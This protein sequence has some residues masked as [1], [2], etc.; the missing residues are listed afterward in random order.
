MQCGLTGSS[1]SKVRKKISGYK[2]GK[3]GS[4][5]ESVLPNRSEILTRGS[6]DPLL[7]SQSEPIHE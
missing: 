2:I 3:E 1:E 5:G 4:A 6:N 7:W